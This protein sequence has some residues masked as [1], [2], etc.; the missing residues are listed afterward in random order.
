GTEIA[1]K[2][3][4][5]GGR[6][7]TNKRLWFAHFFRTGG[8]GFPWPGGGQKQQA[9]AR[10]RELWL[11]N[12]WPGQKYPLSWLVEKFSPIPDWK[13]GNPVWEQVKAAG[14]RFNFEYER[15]QLPVPQKLRAGA[16]YYTCNSHD[17]TL[18]L[19]AR[20]NLR[21]STNGH[22]LGCVALQRTDFGDWT[23]VVNREKSGTTM[24]YQIV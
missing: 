3:W 20:N 10:C 9:M 2:S 24:H 5:S 11:E 6:L 19:A 13:D 14:H 17:E 23:V 22:E 16:I 18:E 21:R 7:V 8:I 12:K 15:V 4:L 1:L